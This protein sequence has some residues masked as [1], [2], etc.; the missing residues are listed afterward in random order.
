M[1]FRS[2][3]SPVPLW[4]GLAV[5]L[6]AGLLLFKFPWPLAVVFF[7]VWMA[8]CIGWC[9]FAFAYEATLRANGETQFRSLFRRRIVPASDVTSIR[10]RWGG[11]GRNIVVH[12]RGSVWL[13]YTEANN[14]LS[15]HIKALN[16]ALEL[17]I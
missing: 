14:E 12:A 11:R 8:N 1:L 2:R 6:G 9:G 16:P 4:A 13:R 17:E 5:G 15:R 3:N 7:V 10:A